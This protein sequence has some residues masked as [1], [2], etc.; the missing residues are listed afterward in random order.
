MEM[1][2]ERD[3]VLDLFLHSRRMYAGV[4]TNGDTKDLTD[5]QIDEVF[6]NAGIS[7]DAARD[8]LAKY[9]AHVIDGVVNAEDPELQAALGSCNVCGAPDPETVETMIATAFFH[10]FLLRTGV[11]SGYEPTENHAE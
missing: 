4:D 1:L 5:E 11:E 10:G 3:Q 6:T 7:I 8:F 2:T 9:A